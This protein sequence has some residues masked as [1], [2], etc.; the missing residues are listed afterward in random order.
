MVKPRDIRSVLVKVHGIGNQPSTWHQEF[1]DLLDTALSDLTPAQRGRFVNESVWWADLSVLPGAT[2]PAALGRP[3]ASSPTAAV[4]VEYGFVYQSYGNYLASGGDPSRGGPAAFGL[5]DPRTIIL[6]LRSG[7]VSAAD[8]AN[9]VAGYVSQNGLRTQ[10]LHRLSA[11]LYEMHDR[12]P[13]AALILG[14]HSQGTMVAYDVL[15]QVGSRLP[16]LRTWITMGSPLAWYVNCARWGQEQ[17]DVPSALTWLNFYDDQDLVGKALA[18]L[19]NWPAPQPDDIDVDNAGQGLH[20]HDHWH[21]PVVVQRYAQ[22]IRQ[23]VET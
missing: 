7:A 9:D 16:R 18:P 17:L 15:R 1:D 3:A 14:S 2:A 11:K 8:Q 22:L 5:P 21:N 20:P 6:N 4:D 12:F 19:V 10:I 23:Q 13:N